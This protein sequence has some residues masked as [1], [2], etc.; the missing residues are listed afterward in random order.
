M[1]DASCV[2]PIVAL[3]KRMWTLSPSSAVSTESTDSK[4]ESRTPNVFS[5]DWNTPPASAVS[6]QSKTASRT[7]DV[8][9]VADLRDKRLL[10]DRHSIYDC[11]YPFRLLDLQTLKAGVLLS[12]EAWMIAHARTYITLSASDCELPDRVALARELCLALAILEYVITEAKVEKRE[13]IVLT[14][15]NLQG[16]TA[17]ICNR[18]ESVGCF[19]CHGP[20]QEG[21]TVRCAKCQLSLLC[22]ECET[23]H[24]AMHANICDNSSAFPLMFKAYLIKGARMCVYCANIDP[25]NAATAMKKCERCRVAHYCT[26]ACLELDWPVHSQKDCHAVTAP[27]SAIDV[28]VDAPQPASS[29]EPAT[30]T[31]AISSSASASAS[32]AATYSVA[33]YSVANAATKSSYGIRSAAPHNSPARLR[34]RQ[35]RKAQR[36]ASKYF[37]TELI[38][39]NA[40]TSTNDSDQPNLNTAAVAT[41]AA[42]T[43]AAT[44]AAATSVASTAADVT[45]AV[46]VAVATSSAS[47][48]ASVTVSSSIRSLPD[49]ADMLE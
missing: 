41:T 34:R 30:I 11:R 10:L 8:F 35:R 38:H 6:N 28:S 29:S 43:R 9:S 1:R 47:T 2:S 20:Y 46:T 45:A 15:S 31:T 21:R 26:R 36:D 22:H 19:V 7:L 18:T 13:M 3:P 14:Y 17:I 40:N 27:I 32:Y 25:S 49:Y 23:K 48:S 33:T 5:V 4:T 39:R 42:S 16:D 12:T 24:M 44:T 37:T